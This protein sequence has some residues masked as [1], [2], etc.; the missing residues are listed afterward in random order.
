MF[1]RV[2]VKTNEVHIVQRK[3]STTPYWKGYNSAVYFNW[4]SWFPVIGIDRIILPVSIFTI[5]L[6][7]YQA[8][9]IGKVPFVVDV[10]AWFQVEE[11]KT[12][13]QRI[14]NFLELNEQLDDILKWAIRK[15]LASDDINNIMTWRHQFGEAFIKEVQKQTWVYGVKTV[16]IEFMDIRDPID[17]S[18][19]VVRDIMEKKKSLIEKE[20]RMEVAENN[21]EAT[22]KEIQTKKDADVQAQEAEKVVW[23]KEAEKEK[24]VWI[25]KEKAEQ[26][27]KEQAKVTAE[28]EMA[29]KQVEE[30][31]SA[32]INKD[33][34]IVKAE[35]IKQTKIIQAEWEK[36]QMIINAEANK[37][38]KI[39]K[40][41]WEKVQIETVANWQK[42]AEFYNAQAIEAVGKAEAEA[43]KLME[44]AP[45]MAQIELAKEIWSNENY[46]EYL[47]NIENIKAW[48]EV[49]VAKAAALESWDLKIIANWQWDGTVDGWMNGLMS[50]FSWKGWT[51]LWNMVEN[52][53]NT[54]IGSRIIERILW[55][56]QE[57]DNKQNQAINK[58]IRH[59]KSKE[60]KNKDSKS[61]K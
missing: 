24:F 49:W 29:V 55:E 46:M 27:I 15:I 14:S 57:T 20:S 17:Q 59:I 13:W 31:R 4:P 6:D 42:Q 53:R 44:L 48:L 5:P 2:V 52:F 3:K 54:P 35:E 45:V 18:S 56:K 41:E 10:K 22:I 36:Q 47:I 34:Q 51:D 19:N 30:V 9:D 33:V 7:A 39:I 38:D 12:A 25:A 58:I 1:F 28:K 23:E 26:E 16:N 11:P 40:A 61:E 43:K 50:V 21:K 37:Q 60:N 8:Y 32:E